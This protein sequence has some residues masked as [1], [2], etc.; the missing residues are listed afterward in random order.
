MWDASPGN[1]WFGK[2]WYH[3]KTKPTPKCPENLTADDNRFINQDDNIDPG[4]EIE[5]LD[6]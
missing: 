3:I 5:C 6:Q 1:Y 2:K 4:L